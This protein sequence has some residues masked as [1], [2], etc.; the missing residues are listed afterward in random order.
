MLNVLLF[1]GTL[2]G[3]TWLSF[4]RLPVFAFVLYQAIYFYYPQQRWWGYMVP[5]IGYS[6]IS[7]VIM[8]LVFLLNMKSLQ[9]Q[10]PL[11]VAPLRYFYLLVALYAITY[12]YSARP[13]LHMMFATNYVKLAIIMTLA[14]KLCS[15]KK[16]LDIILYGYIF[17]AWYLSFVAYQ[18]GRQFGDR[19]EGVY[20]IDAPDVNFVG[21]ALTPSLVLCLYFFWIKNH[22]LQRLIFVIAGAFIANAIVLI[23]SRGAYLGVAL[24]VAYFM[25]HMFFSSFQRKYQKATT[26]FILVAGL[27]SLTVVMDSSSIERILSIKQNTEVQENKETAATRTVFWL[28]AWEM[29]KDYPLGSGYEGFSYYS[30]GYI[31]ANVNTGRSR[32]RAVHSTWFETL[33]EVGYIGIMLFILMLYSSFK[34]SRITREYLKKRNMVD[35]Y[36]KMFALEGAL[37][38]FIIAMTFI[39]RMRAEVL[40]WCILFICVAYNVYVLNNTRQE[41]DVPEKIREQR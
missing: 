31:P 16:S 17:G 7:V 14:F 39:N 35:E 12:F 10:K 23:N 3:F 37:F 34:V 1:C 20:T 11:S 6:F 32:N 27:A 36:F 2:F 22:I 26:M 21:A 9:K 4:V 24:S 5:D 41:N 18:V 38:S 33:S 8:A 29:A 28:A 13:E 19:L 15:T 40:Y 30:H 25:Y